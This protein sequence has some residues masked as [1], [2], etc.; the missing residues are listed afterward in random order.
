MS[1]VLAIFF[2][3]GKVFTNLKGMEKPTWQ[4]PF[5]IVL[6]VIAL[7]AA[8]TVSAT[9]GSEEV[10]MRQEEA[11]R[12]RGLTE[13][14]IEQAKQFT[15]GPLPVILGGVGGALVTAIMLLVFALLLN[16]FIPAFGGA[17]GYAMVF[18]VA[19]Y[20]AM[21][22]VPSAILKLILVLVTESPFIATSLALLAPGIEKTSFLWRFLNSFDFF[23]IWEMI[24]VAMGITITRDVKKT[25]AYFLVFAIWF[26]SIFIGI[27]LQ[28]LGG[29]PQ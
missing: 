23:V 17:K 1:N 14:Q 4:A 18:A 22:L 25:S 28:S 16:L 21:V 20:A 6:I 2:S 7:S 24:L 5:I 10:I 26:V 29:G 15:Q 19:C 11:L 9:Q 27:G 3:P 13:E 8:F 12:E